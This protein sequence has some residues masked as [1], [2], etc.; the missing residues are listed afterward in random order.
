MMLLTAFVLLIGFV[1]LAGMVARVSQLADETAQESRQGTVLDAANVL[2]GVQDAF[3]R[4]E[5]YEPP[6]DAVATQ[7]YLDSVTAAV[8]HID[9]LQSARGFQFRAGAIAC[10][11]GVTPTQFSVQVNVVRNDVQVAATVVHEVTGAVCP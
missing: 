5:A 3:E 2:D 9:A 6:G 1:A 7:A 8:A 11:D 4:M 10:N